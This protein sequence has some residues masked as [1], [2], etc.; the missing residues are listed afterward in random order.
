MTGKIS[1]R[2]V[3]AQT[4]ESIAG[5]NVILEGT[6]LGSATDM[7]GHYF[8]INVAPG[9]Y[10]VMCS[11]IGYTTV[12]KTQVYV[13]AD[14]TTTVDFD[15]SVEVI[16]GESVTVV[17][18]RPIIQPD[19]AG[20]EMV[21]REEDVA[22]FKQDFFQDFMESQVGIFISA[23]EEGSGLSIRGGD[24]N[25]TN[26][27]LN[28]VS[29]RNAIT[30]QPNLGISLTS[31]QEVTITTG[32]FTAEY[33][34]IRSGMVNVITKEGSPDRFAVSIDARMGPPQY[35]HFGPN[36]FGV[37]GPIWNVYCGDKAF[38][39]V[40]AADV[41]GG[42]Y[43]FEFIGWNKM[44]EQSLTDGDPNNNYTPQ[45]WM[46]IWRHTHQNIPYAQ[47]PDYIFDGTLTGP[48]LFKNS[49]FLLSQHYENLQLA[50]PYSRTNSVQ[51]TTQANF[52]LRLSPKAKMTFTYMHILEQGVATQA[53]DYT[54]GMITG[55]K[56]GTQLARDVR[57]HMLYNPY[58]IN[59][60]DRN[61]DLAGIKFSHSL[62]ERTFYNLSLTGSYYSAFQGVTTHRDTSHKVL[63]GDA[64]LDPS[65][66]TGFLHQSDYYDMFDQFWIYG[67]GRQIDDSE[68]WQLR[69]KGLLESQLTFR[70]LLKVGF[71]AAY[72]QY[73][74]RAAKIHYE[75]IDEYKP[76]YF[77]EGPIPEDTY[78]FEDHPLQL[79]AFIQNKLEY[80]GM[81]AN[82]GLRFEYFNAMRP[83]WLI[84]AEGD[85]EWYTF[86]TEDEWR[87][88]DEDSN[89]VNLGFKD[90]LEDENAVT[91]KISPR[92][93]VSFPATATSKFYFNYGHF[94]QLPVPGQLFNI[95][96]GNNPKIPNLNAEWPRT[97]MYE[98]GFE[99]ALAGAYLFRIS[100]YY[101]DITNQLTSGGLKF[102][103]YYKSEVY[104]TEVNNSYEDIRGI[105]IRLQK[106]HGRF[107]YGWI[108]FEYIS[109]NEGWTGFKALHENWQYEQEQRE[110]A[111]QVQNWPVPKVST[112]YSFL[113][114]GNFGPEIL[115]F[116]PLS[117]WALQ[118][119]AWWRAGGKRLFGDPSNP[120]P[121][122]ARN[123]MDRIDRH[124][125]DL[126]LRKGF[127]IGHLDFS[128]FLRVR[129]A[130]NFK[131]EV[132]PY[133]GEQYRSSL[134]LP[135]YE[136][137]MHGHDK[138]GE[139]PSDEKP[140]IDAGWQNWRWYLNPRYIMF[141]FDL[142]IN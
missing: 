23:D 107:G 102:Y 83:A 31:V 129:N 55:T 61:T 100:A 19:V 1:G 41:E 38:E 128:V 93:G 54:S 47:E 28:G 87:R 2:V 22:V 21:M 139:G 105:E 108:D 8:I 32:G 130:T 48:F 70:H 9:F 29:L 6:M 118:I 51:S 40:T 92:L 43:A 3:D 37:N 104:S 111:E 4:G 116:K 75:V 17:A 117:S 82:L 34:D 71:E 86:Y 126:I 115:G 45:Q 141:G 119:N 63:V 120:P 68:Y 98:V 88:V 121:V 39:G 26:I 94:Y 109:T 69:L 110:N 85:E 27:S 99:K 13:A 84:N 24:I 35:K 57:W 76:P 81:N 113:L 138:Y 127:D 33:G 66:S 112:V 133:S 101:K 132:I 11:V 72:T 42:D 65:P 79:A 67:G 135:W 89:F 20:S 90:Q 131:G 15:L 106:R 14:L 36:P 114:P 52:N 50:Y 122:W 134:H 49:T 124:N 125:V 73:N 96:Q 78:Y 5:A 103:D 64:Y 58:G 123:Y 18:Q 142:N 59:P 44:S 77:E 30:Q 16:R 80:E 56:E 46:E 140:W 60:I 25:E 53:Q 136:G 7:D 137:E 10:T 91:F 12:R 62:S 97:V 74:M 95:Q